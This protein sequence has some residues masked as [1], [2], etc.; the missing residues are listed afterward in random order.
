MLRKVWRGE[1]ALGHDGPAGKY[2]VLHMDWGKQEEI[3]LL[4]TAFG[5]NSLALGG[6]VF[7]G[8]ILQT[9]FGADGDRQAAITGEQVA[10]RVGFFLRVDDFDA[11]N[12]PMSCAGVEFMT[13][14]QTEVYGRFAV[15]RDIA[16]NRWDLLGPA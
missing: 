10:C 14:P 11:A 5:P 7:D 15:F 16:G 9:Y 4:F 12:E 6:R 8:V 13:A 1:L 2:P 3:P